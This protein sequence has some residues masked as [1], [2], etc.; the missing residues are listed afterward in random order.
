MLAFSKRKEKENGTNFAHDHQPVR[1]LYQTL[2]GRQSERRGEQDKRDCRVQDAVGEPADVDS[3]RRSGAREAPT[4]LE[5]S[6][7][8]N[9]AHARK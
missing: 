2:D 9:T 1:D 7:F 5:V 3:R 6:K 8:P 4:L